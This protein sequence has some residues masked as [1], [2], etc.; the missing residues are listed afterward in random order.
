MVTYGDQTG[1]ARKACNALSFLAWHKHPGGPSSAVDCSPSAALK[2]LAYEG[3]SVLATLSR[4]FACSQHQGAQNANAKDIILRA[5]P[6]F[7]P[8]AGFTLAILPLCAKADAKK[9]QAYQSTA[10]A[11]LR[12]LPSCVMNSRHHAILPKAQIKAYHSLP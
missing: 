7:P 11:L 3:C 8:F 10:I 12:P 9:G 1:T 6:S 2:E 5:F 4:P